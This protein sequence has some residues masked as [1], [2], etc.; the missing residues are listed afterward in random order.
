LN[1]PQPCGISGKRL[2]DLKSRLGR[3]AERALLAE[4][5]PAAFSLNLAK[6]DLQLGRD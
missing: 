4:S 3:E 6:A 1:P 2:P 5:G